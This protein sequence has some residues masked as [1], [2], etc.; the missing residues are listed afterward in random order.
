MNSHTTVIV[1]WYGPYTYDEICEN[2]DWENGLYLATGKLKYE[3]EATIQ[4]CG[5]TEGSYIGRLKN[6]H[7]VHEITKEQEFWIGEIAYPSNASRHFL[8]MA[9]SMIIYFWQPELNERKK[10]SL[11][12]PVT[13]INKWYKKDNSPK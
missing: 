3:R 2:P 4:Y 8:E 5:I 12:K 9:E 6:H 11:P 1:E 13:L 7:K 10:L